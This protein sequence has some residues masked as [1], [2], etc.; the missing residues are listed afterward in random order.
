MTIREMLTE[1]IDSVFTTE[2]KKRG[3][4]SGDVSPLMSLNLDEKTEQ[5]AEIIEQ[6][7]NAQETQQTRNR[8]YVIADSV[9]GMLYFIGMET[10]SKTEAVSEFRARWEAMTE[11]Q[12]NDR[13]YYE[14]LYA[15][16]DGEDDAIETAEIIDKAK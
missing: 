2:Q 11:K 6:I 1:A 3:I 16:D 8:K 12:R 9:D 5:L 10:D 15:Y 14:L 13:S 7:L 4:M